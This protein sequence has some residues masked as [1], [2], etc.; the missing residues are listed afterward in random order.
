MW[1]TPAVRRILAYNK[2]VDLRKS[3]TGLVGVVK[4]VVEEDPLS[5]SLCVFLT[6]RGNSLKLV[7]W[8]RTGFCLFAK[9]WERG[10]VRLPGAAP[11]QELSTQGFQLLLDGLELGGRA[12]G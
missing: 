12:A 7:V 10:R 6:R 8:D 2:P 3:I 5:G 9:R 4:R 1:C 11:T